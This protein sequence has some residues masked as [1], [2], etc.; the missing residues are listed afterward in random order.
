MSAV[1]HG[2]PTSLTPDLMK[3][4]LR[5]EPRH[6]RRAMKPRLVR[7]SPEV[8]GDLDTPSDDA[9][10]PKLHERLMDPTNRH[11]FEAEAR[12]H[13]TRNRPRSLYKGKTSPGR[14]THLPTINGM[15]PIPG[16]WHQRLPFRTGPIGPRRHRAGATPQRRIPKPSMQC[17]A[18]DG[19]R[20]PIG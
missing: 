1:K 11:H 16:A 2:L 19:S 9:F 13:D 20:V 14:P 3:E 18:P 17:S 4:I 8:W 12:R 5:Y 6:W 15:K 10:Y 7:K